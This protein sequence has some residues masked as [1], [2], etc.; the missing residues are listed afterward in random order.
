M[1]TGAIAATARNSRTK[2]A[3]RPA[4]AVAPAPS[5]LEFIVARFGPR[6]VVGRRTKRKLE[7]YPDSVF[8]TPAKWA[9]I[10]RDFATQYPDAAPRYFLN[11]QP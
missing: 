5:F 8:L 1:G 9:A 2:E 10:K 4:G 7:L 3:G 11:S 6:F